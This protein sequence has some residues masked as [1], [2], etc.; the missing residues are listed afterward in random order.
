MKRFLLSV[1]IVGLIC[2]PLICD[3]ADAFEAED[4]VE[5]IAEETTE[6]IASA[7]G[8]AEGCPPAAVGG[9]EGE[10]APVWGGCLPGGV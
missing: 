10:P 1:L 4:V 3:E 5:E 2:F 7:G 8:Y 6:V 9:R